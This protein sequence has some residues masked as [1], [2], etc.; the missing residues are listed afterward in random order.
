MPKDFTTHHSSSQQEKFHVYIPLSN[1]SLKPNTTFYILI[2]R[3]DGFYLPSSSRFTPDEVVGN[4]TIVV[5]KMRTLNNSQCQ[6]PFGT[7]LSFGDICFV[8]AK[9]NR[10]SELGC[11]IIATLSGKQVHFTITPPDDE[12][13]TV[14]LANYFT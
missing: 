14:E 13:I 12:T 11:N 2:S 7:T 10:S 6:I 8:C 1:D 3:I 9:L 4:T 5:L